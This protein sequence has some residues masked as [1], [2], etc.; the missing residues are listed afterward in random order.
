MQ[1]A[2]DHAW[3]GTTIVDPDRPAGSSMIQG[4]NTFLIPAGV[5]LPS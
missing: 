5:T 2:P 1:D 3:Q 4:L